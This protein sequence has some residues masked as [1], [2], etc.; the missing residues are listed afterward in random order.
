[1]QALRRITVSSASGEGVDIKRGQPRTRAARA[2]ARR[3]VKTYEAS[4][5]HRRRSRLI[6]LRPLCLGVLSG[7]PE[8]FALVSGACACPIRLY[9]LPHPPRPPSLSQHTTPSPYLHSTPDA[10]TIRIRRRRERERGEGVPLD[11]G[12]QNCR[13]RC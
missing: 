6:L 7:G 4:S 3:A 8:S 5:L 2:G 9:A 13:N 10:K 12:P 11:L 1:M